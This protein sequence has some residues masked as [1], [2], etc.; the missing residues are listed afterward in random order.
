[1]AET[2]D[3]K[4]TVF[5][6]LI[7]E[8]ICLVSR[9]TTEHLRQRALH[10][11]DKDPSIYNKLMEQ[12]VPE[13]YIQPE[14]LQRLKEEDAQRKADAAVG[15]KPYF[16]PCDVHPDDPKPLPP[17]PEKDDVCRIMREQL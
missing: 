14:N 2:S 10:R 7:E 17:C 5:E 16:A 8:E 13:Y 9:A 12:T 4:G 15:G 3:R 11:E 6:G 1:M